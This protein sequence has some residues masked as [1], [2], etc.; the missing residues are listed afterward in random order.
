MQSTL[1]AIVPRLILALQILLAPALAAAQD[2]H[3]AQARTTLHI[4]GMVSET[5]PVLVRSAVSRIPGV[6]NV[7]ASFKTKSA[8][9]EYDANT[10]TLAEIRQI[11]RDKAGLDS[12][13]AQ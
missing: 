5:C 8:T 13:V 7:E 6:R 3:G 10:T 12:E 11:I 4:D 1:T 9:V 2:G